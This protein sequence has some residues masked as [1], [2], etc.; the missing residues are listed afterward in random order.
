[1]LSD[2]AADGIAV[3]SVGMRSP[4]SVRQI[5]ERKNPDTAVR[6][7]GNFL[8]GADALS[9]DRQCVG[10]SALLPSPRSECSRKSREMH[11]RAL[12]PTR[13]YIILLT[14]LPAPP[15]IHATI[16]NLN[17]PM[18]PQLIPPMIRIQSAI[19]SSITLP[20][21]CLEQRPHVFGRT[22]I[23]PACALFIHFAVKIKFVYIR[24]CARSVTRQMKTAINCCPLHACGARE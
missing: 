20:F 8:Y 12:S 11:H 10:Q 13:V 2:S 22:V 15:K 6:H 3:I 23:L 17:S 1:M 9:A 14:T 16:S 21:L 24:A 18:L 5:N 4:I 19:L 7:I